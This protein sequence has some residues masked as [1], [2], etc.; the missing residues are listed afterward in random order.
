MTSV[1]MPFATRDI[2]YY[3]TKFLYRLSLLKAVYNK[4]HQK[5]TKN[6]THIKTLTFAEG[7]CVFDRTPWRL[8][9]KRVRNM[10]SEIAIH[11]NYKKNITNYKSIA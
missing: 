8:L 2:I 3:L 11:A 1:K 10:P 5:P 6:L 9:L 4:T 7:C